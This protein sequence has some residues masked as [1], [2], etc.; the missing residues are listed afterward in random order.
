MTRNEKTFL[1]R[2]E[3]MQRVT[4]ADLKRLESFNSSHP[5][6]L[7]ADKLKKLR[8]ERVYT[9]LTLREVI[10]TFH[11][12]IVAPREDRYVHVSVVKRLREQIA[13]LEEELKYA[14]V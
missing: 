9:S 12:E 14:V 11:K 10:R 13:K 7:R 5:G 1:K 8:Y 6:N 2:L 3:K 4:K